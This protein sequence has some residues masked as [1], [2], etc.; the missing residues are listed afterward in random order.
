MRAYRPLLLLLLLGACKSAVAPAA[1]SL[2]IQTHGSEFVRSPSEGSVSVP[3]TIA[4][5]GTGSV[6]VERCGDRIMAAV[7]RHE[8]GEWV[9][10]YDACLGI[11]LMTRAEILPGQVLEGT[12]AILQPGEYRLRVA[13]DGGEEAAWSGASNRFTVR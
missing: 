4:N 2:R 11:Y 1:T 5:H 6:F 7:D 8:E 3:F 9:R 10:G 12:R 13:V